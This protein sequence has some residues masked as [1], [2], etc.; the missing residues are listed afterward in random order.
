M[1]PTGRGEA[2]KNLYDGRYLFEGYPD[3]EKL[4]VK[5]FKRYQPTQT[6]ILEIMV[7]ISRLAV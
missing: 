6:N 5:Y 2:M 4:G 3:L 7:C 1:R